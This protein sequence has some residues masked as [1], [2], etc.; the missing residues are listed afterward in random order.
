MAKMTAILPAKYAVDPEFNA[1]FTASAP[2]QKLYTAYWSRTP[3]KM[4]WTQQREK[5]SLRAKDAN[6]TEEDFEQRLRDL[7]CAVVVNIQILKLRF[8][9]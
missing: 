5:C 3:E 9:F 6:E 2:N 1:E 4:S 8:K 7:I